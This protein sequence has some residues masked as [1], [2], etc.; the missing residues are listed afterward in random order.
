VAGN[1]GGAQPFFDRLA[2]CV[3]IAGFSASSLETHGISFVLALVRQ[4]WK[5][6]GIFDRQE[7]LDA[8]PF[9]DMGEESSTGFKVS[10]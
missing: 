6:S 2:A 4:R 10:S 7:R 9:G 5:L 1:T 3:S 8:S